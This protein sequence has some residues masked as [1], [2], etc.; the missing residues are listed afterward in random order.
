M[1]RQSNVWYLTYLSNDTH[2]HVASAPEG[3]WGAPKG[4]YNSD[5]VTAG[6]RTVSDGRRRLNW[7]FFS[8]RPTPESPGEFH[9]RRALAA[10]RPT[11]AQEKQTEP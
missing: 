9:S 10:Q 1:F 3:P 6:S 11:F 7:G 4:Q 5:F 2:Y 8:V